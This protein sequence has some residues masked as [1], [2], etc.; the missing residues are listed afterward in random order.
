MASDT[1]ADFFLSWASQVRP[2][3]R[4][5]AQAAATREA[6]RQRN[7]EAHARAPDI[8]GGPVDL[9]S[10][11]TPAPA[12]PPPQN[13]HQAG[14]PPPPR[15]AAS[16]ALFTSPSPSWRSAS[17]AASATARDFALASGHPAAL[18]KRLG[19]DD[20]TWQRA[21]RAELLQEPSEEDLRLLRRARG[22]WTAA[23]L[24]DLHRCLV[25]LQD[26]NIHPTSAISVL[27]LE[28]VRE[29]IA[30]AKGH[31]EGDYAQAAERTR[32]AI[33]ARA[34][35]SWVPRNELGVPM[36]L[37]Q[38]TSEPAPLD[39]RDRARSV[40][41]CPRDCPRP[42]GEHAPRQ[43]NPD[44]APPPPPAYH[45]ATS[46]GGRGSQQGRG[47]GGRGRVRGKATSGVE[48]RVA[49]TA[50]VRPPG[51]SNP[52]NR[53]AINAVCAALGAA[54]DAD[55]SFHQA[56]SLVP[57]LDRAVMRGASAAVAEVGTHLGLRLGPLASI[58]AID[59]VLFPVLKVL[60]AAHAGRGKYL[61]VEWV[62][63]RGIGNQRLGH[64]AAPATGDGM[65]AVLHHR[66]SATS[67]HWYA[68]VLMRGEWWTIDDES[69]APYLGDP[70]EPS[71]SAC[72][73]LFA[74]GAP[75]DDRCLDSVDAAPRPPELAAV[76]AGA[77]AVPAEAKCQ[78]QTKRHRGCANRPVMRRDGQ[79]WCAQHGFP[80]GSQGRRCTAS[81][82]RGLPC[83]HLAVDGFALCPHHL[84]AEVWRNASAPDES[85]GTS[86][87]PVVPGERHV[88]TAFPCGLQPATPQEAARQG[89]WA[90]EILGWE[91]LPIG[92]L[93]PALTAAGLSRETRSAHLRLLASVQATLMKVVPEASRLPLPAALVEWLARQR[94]AKNWSWTTTSTKFGV[95]AGALKALPLY[96]PGGQTVTL[97]EDVIWAQAAAAAEREARGT[98]IN[99]AVAATPQDM[100][101]AIGRATPQLGSLLTI[102][103][104]TAARIGCV[105]Q[106]RSEDVTLS[107]AGVLRVLFRRGKAV[108]LRRQPYTV[109]SAVEAS[110]VPGLRAFLAGANGFLWP[111]PTQTARLALGASVRM[112]L[113]AVRR[114][115]SQR[116]VRRGAL[117]AAATA[118]ASDSELMQLSGHASAKML[119]RY[120]GW[121]ALSATA[122]A[123]GRATADALAVPP[124]PARRQ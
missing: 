9:D 16:H 41:V 90:Q 85:N 106:L 118:G 31:D 64:P 51:R 88:T 24:D 70:A 44:A 98:P 79:W 7:L 42:R 82:A 56:L 6:I 71:A 83:V 29:F 5:S 121:G 38:L 20:A 25:L 100:A 69:V 80:A 105:T 57:G 60:R 49:P 68:S 36:H 92:R 116:S 8:A 89:R 99:Q 48:V 72:G 26:G 43:S 94:V 107:D 78:G 18:A 113:R 115:L 39:Y 32:V 66:G 123:A 73:Y 91:L 86:C 102:A 45:A 55:P 112:A 4:R 50:D 34:L 30:E 101:D 77:R 103:W 15:T 120:L 2:E 47:L 46:Q 37:S 117:Q 58:D 93:S 114:G 11:Y 75:S 17:A 84:G 110:R 96:S 14:P 10:P 35:D 22:V 3:V 53:C 21:E 111:A 76:I 61:H 67:G 19:W 12:P 40:L 74:R 104:A 65:V 124:R 97:H 63:R 95:L 59:E 27:T 1:E 109:H 87:P 28:R 23:E 122:A 52:D 81:S 108:R 54:V 13:A 119:H 62:D 33:R